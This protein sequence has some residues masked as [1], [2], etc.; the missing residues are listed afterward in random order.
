MTPE[1]FENICEALRGRL[2]ALVKKFGERRLRP[3]CAEDIVQEA[4][5]VLW[6]ISE[7]GRPIRN[8]EALAVTIVKNICVSQYRRG[9]KAVAGEAELPSG[10]TGG[11]EAT[12]R[13]DA[14]DIAGIKGRLY[15]QLSASQRRYLDMRNEYGLSL[16]EIAAITGK[17]KSSIKT[18]ISTARRRLLEMLKK[19]VS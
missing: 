17:P 14:D 12:E 18:T 7:S 9:G 10:C 5:A 16:D 2:T 15:A 6:R 1:E 19:E 11:Y 8:P 13:T 3:L 4:L